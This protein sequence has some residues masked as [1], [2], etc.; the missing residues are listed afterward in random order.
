MADDYI[1][2]NVPV[3]R[4]DVDNRYTCVQLAGGLYVAAVLDEQ[5]ICV[6][7]RT[8]RTEAEA[9]AKLLKKLASDS[10]W[11]KDIE[12][13]YLRHCLRTLQAWDERQEAGE[14]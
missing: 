2:V 13:R 7:S 11:W 8:G 12:D 9:V 4:Q 6:A 5:G 10:L 1:P 14:R 3:D